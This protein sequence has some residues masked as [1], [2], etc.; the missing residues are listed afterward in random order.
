MRAERQGYGLRKD[1]LVKNPG[2]EQT[3]G[4]F[5]QEVANAIADPDVRTRTYARERSITFADRLMTAFPEDQEKIGLWIS[6]EPVAEF[7]EVAG[8]IINEARNR[9]IQRNGK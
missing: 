6:N 2:S 1:H 3:Y 8:D 9:R 5:R 7:G 4:M